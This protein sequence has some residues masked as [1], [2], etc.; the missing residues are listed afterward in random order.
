MY[1]NVYVKMDSL[2]LEHQKVKGVYN[3]GYNHYHNSYEIYYLIQG[4]RRYFLK[5][6]MY[7]LTKGNLVF[8]NI[9]DL[10][11]SGQSEKAK[12]YYERVA[13]NFKKEYLNTMLGEEELS[14]LLNINSGVYTPDFE[15]NNM[16]EEL[17]FKMLKEKKNKSPNSELYI[18]TL[19]LQL[20]IT[21]NRNSKKYIM[22]DETE[23]KN[24]NI[25][26]T[27]R[28]MVIWGLKE[29]VLSNVFLNNLT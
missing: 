5:D 9:N 11:R 16:I 10:H 2:F 25:V 17:I 4:Q 13:I 7:N 6:R 22:H 20:L 18:K 28:R 27:R 14:S 29:E 8:I 15:G 24:E 3:M 12:L 23:N 21:L 19:L 1:L 26:A